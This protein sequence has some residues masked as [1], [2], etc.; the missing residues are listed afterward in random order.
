MFPAEEY[1]SSETLKSR[2]LFYIIGNH[3]L[4]SHTLIKMIKKI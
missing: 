2:M 3:I 1:D 4:M